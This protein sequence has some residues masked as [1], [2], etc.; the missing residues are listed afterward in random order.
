MPK[1][2]RGQNVAI[3]TLIVKTDMCISSKRSNSIQLTMV[4]EG[5]IVKSHS[6]PCPDIPAHV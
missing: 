2:T 5:T 4:Q 3:D 1:E 6:E